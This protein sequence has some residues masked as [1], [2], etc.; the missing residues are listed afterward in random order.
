MPDRARLR[1]LLLEARIDAPVR[2]HECSCILSSAELD[3]SQVDILDVLSTPLDSSLL[4]QYDAFFIGGTGDFK[5]SQHRPEWYAP[6]RAFTL[7]LLE[8]GKPLLGICYGLHVMAE[9]V[10]GVV[11]HKPEEGEIGTHEVELTPE[12]IRDVIFQ[13]VPPRFE[14]QQG[15]HDV[16]THVPE[17]YVRLARSHNCEWQA[18]RHPVKPFYAIQFHPELSRDDFLY[19]M[20]TYGGV[21]ARDP[22][23]YRELDQSVRETR[24]QDI[25]KRW[26][27]CV[28]VPSVT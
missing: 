27:D 14:A 9:A 23:V 21:Y 3:R 13:G 15:H 24:V 4:S 19:R 22:E 5:V 1:F 11:E 6:L 12:G 25:M 10:G 20:R 18:F 2:E 16:V 28:V 7:D 8:L 26:I 17:P